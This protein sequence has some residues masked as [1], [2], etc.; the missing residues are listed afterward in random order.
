MIFSLKLQE[1]FSDE[2]KSTGQVALKTII[3]TRI[4]VILAILPDSFQIGKKILEEWKGVHIKFKVL[5]T[6]L[7]RRRATTPNK[8]NSRKEMREQTRGH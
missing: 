4:H 3:N 7:L 8:E 5:Q 1:L 2:G 6:L